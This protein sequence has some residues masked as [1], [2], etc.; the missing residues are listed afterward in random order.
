MQFRRKCMNQTQNEEKKELKIP[1]IGKKALHNMLVQ[2]EQ[3]ASIENTPL[4]AKRKKHMQPTLSWR[5]LSKLKNAKLT[6]EM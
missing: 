6:G 4:T 3:F 1:D 2:V 5:L